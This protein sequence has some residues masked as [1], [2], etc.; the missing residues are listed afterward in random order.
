MYHL[1]ARAGVLLPLM[2]LPA[3]GQAM[4]PAAPQAPASDDALCAATFTYLAGEAQAQGI[5]TGAF[6]AMAATVQQA[7]QRARPGD[8]PALFDQQVQA[9]AAQ[10]RQAMLGGTTNLSAV[11]AQVASCNARYGAVSAGGAAP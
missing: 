9:Q 10:I 7:H 6:E 5:S 1:I 4:A 3:L 2:S 8:D 11:Q